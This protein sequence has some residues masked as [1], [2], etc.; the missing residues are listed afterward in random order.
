MLQGLQYGAGLA[1][2]EGAGL[3]YV[4][5]VVCRADAAYAGCGAAFDLVQQA[6]AGAVAK[7]GVFTGAQ[8]EYFLQ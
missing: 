6:G 7:Y 1:F 8:A 3:G 2:E 5:G 4:A